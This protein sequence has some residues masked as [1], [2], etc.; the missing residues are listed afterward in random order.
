VN[1]HRFNV[2]EDKVQVMVGASSEDIK[3]QDTIE[4]VR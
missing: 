4:V 2:E 1:K 3:L